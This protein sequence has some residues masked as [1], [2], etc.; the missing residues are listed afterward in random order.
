MIDPGQKA[1][2]FELPSTDGEKVSLR[3]LTADKPVVVVFYPF[4]FTKVCEGELCALR[5]DLS[6]FTESGAQV[7]AISC[8]SAPSQ[9]EWA[10]AQGW[11]FPVLSDFWPHGE[12]ARAYDVFNE[13]LGCAMRGTF[14]IGTDGVIV[15]AFESGG[16]GEARTTERY[17]EAMATLGS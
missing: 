5:D 14:V 4:T 3:A 17:R 16:L 7:V 11:N 2:D 15:D 8:D 10:K 9:K 1:P 12:V 13:A 6:V